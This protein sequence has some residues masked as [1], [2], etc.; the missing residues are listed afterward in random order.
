M[1]K[2][3]ILGVGFLLCSAILM[4]GCNTDVKQ[5]FQ[6]KHSAEGVVSQEGNIRVLTPGPGDSVT[7]PIEVT[8]QARVFENVLMVRVLDDKGNVVGEEN[9]Q[10]DSPDVGK[11]GDFRAS[12]HGVTSAK[13]GT[14]HVFNYSARDG[15][16]SNVVDVPIT[17]LH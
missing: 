14:V 16:E 1:K 15:S 2:K 10:A 3:L 5:Y 11:F 12:I 13:K 17:F 7:F 8:G 4:S 9:T 6:P